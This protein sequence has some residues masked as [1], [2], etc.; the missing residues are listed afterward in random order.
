MFLAVWQHLI[1]RHDTYILRYGEFQWTTMTTVTTTTDRWTDHFI[2]YTYVQS[3][4]DIYI[5]LYD[6]YEGQADTL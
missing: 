2:P 3:K 6:T 5:S 1:A 4:D